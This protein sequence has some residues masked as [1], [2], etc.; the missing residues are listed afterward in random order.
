[1]AAVADTFDR[2]V[3]LQTKTV[4]RDSSGGMVETWA[5]TATVW[6]SV[7]DMRV[8]DLM[9]AEQVGSA[10]RRVVTIRYLSGVTAAMRIKFDDNAIARIVAPPSAIGRH[11]LMEIHA[12][13]V[14][15]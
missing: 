3:T 7:K 10:V 12:E 15:V 8:R 2:H 11:D 14:D 5:D 13:V 4:T 6:A 1:M 9:K